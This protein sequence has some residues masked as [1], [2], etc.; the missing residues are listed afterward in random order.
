LVYSIR[1]YGSNTD[2]MIS[3]Y[4]GGS[5][6]QEQDAQIDIAWIVEVD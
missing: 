5:H 3:M 6:W 1:L 2:H 4:A